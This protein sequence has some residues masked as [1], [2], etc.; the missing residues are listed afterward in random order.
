MEVS[1]HTNGAHK[2]SKDNNATSIFIGLLK[3]AQKTRVP[4]QESSASKDKV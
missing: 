4:Q 2:N 3:T 1:L